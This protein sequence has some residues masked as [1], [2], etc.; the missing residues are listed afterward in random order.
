MKVKNELLTTLSL[1]PG[2]VRLRFPHEK[3][4][5]P[6]LDGF[7]K[8]IGV[9]EVTYNKVTKSILILYDV[10]LLTLE[11]LF[12]EIE[13]KM[14]QVEIQGEKLE[15]IKSHLVEED[16]GSL[17]PRIVHAKSKRLDKVFRELIGDNADIGSLIAAVLVITGIV[18]LFKRSK[19]P[20]WDNLIWYG[21]NIFYWQSKKWE[22]IVN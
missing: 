8:I 2:R 6:E 5:I 19:L 15:Q 18:D 17:L 7:L 4:D 3:A 21:A 10:N 14:P 9:Q 20:S 22:G 1:A 16:N 13:E 11:E 12:S